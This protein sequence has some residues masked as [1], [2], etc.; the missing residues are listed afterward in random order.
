MEAVIRVVGKGAR[1]GAPAD[2]L[3]AMRR[4]L[5][6]IHQIGRQIYTRTTLIAV[7]RVLTSGYCGRG[8]R[9]MVKGVPPMTYPRKSLVSIKDT[10]YYHCVSRCVRR[11]WFWGLRR[12]RREA[13][14]CASCTLRHSYIHVQQTTRIA[15]SGSLI[16]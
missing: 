16:D 4:L 15:N 2:A 13:R 8:W 1:K 5:R 10:P 9:L 3:K 7:D 12:V 14:S 6:D 11:A